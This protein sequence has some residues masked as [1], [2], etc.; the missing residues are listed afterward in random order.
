LAVTPPDRFERYPELRV[1][2]SGL[3]IMALSSLLAGAA[4]LVGAP[5]LTLVSDAGLHFI[6]F[7]ATIA[8]LPDI[9]RSAHGGCHCLRQLG[10]QL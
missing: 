10:T 5:L 7:T 9:E 6:L 3:C 8:I 4:V 2:V 1:A